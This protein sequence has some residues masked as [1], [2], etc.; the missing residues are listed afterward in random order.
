V[1]PLEDIKLLNKESAKVFVTVDALL[2]TKPAKNP[3]TQSLEDAPHRLEVSSWMA[4]MEGYREYLYFV[5]N[6][7]AFYGYFLGVLCYYFD[8]DET[9]PFHVGKLK[10]GLKTEHADW[11]G[12]FAGDFMWTIE[13]VVILVSPIILNH[14]KPKAPKAKLE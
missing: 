12:N 9:Q 3:I 11:H 2:T 14:L 5:L 7:V 10:L 1:D 13:P 8:D 4:R 6:L